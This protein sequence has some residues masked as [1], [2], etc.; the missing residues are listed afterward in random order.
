MG[1]EHEGSGLGLHLVYNLVTQKL[2]GNIIVE[3]ALGLGA[4]FMITLPISVK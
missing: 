4:T 2:N 1:R 3:S